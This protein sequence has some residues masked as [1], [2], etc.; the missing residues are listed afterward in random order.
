MTTTAT[1]PTQALTTD[2]VIAWLEAVRDSTA[3]VPYAREMATHALNRLRPPAIDFWAVVGALVGDLGTLRAN[4][5]ALVSDR[6]THPSASADDAGYYGGY[7]VGESIVPRNAIAM[8]FLPQLLVAARDTPHGRAILAQLAQELSTPAARR[9][10][11]RDRLDGCIRLAR[12]SSEFHGGA[13]SLIDEMLI[14]ST[15]LEHIAGGL[16]SGRVAAA[17]ADIEAWLDQKRE[18]RHAARTGTAS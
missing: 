2:P 9:D 4:H 12:L 6:P 7:L 17:R 14:V 3:T 5:G 13:G 10:P 16:L 11:V 15:M 18:A 8:S 1:A